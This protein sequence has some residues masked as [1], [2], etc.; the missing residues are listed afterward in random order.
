M[1]EQ[2]QIDWEDWL[3]QSYDLDELLDDYPEIDI[4]RC[5]KKCNCDLQ[6]LMARGCQCGGK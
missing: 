3:T 2:K 1:T 4:D 6:T 5:E